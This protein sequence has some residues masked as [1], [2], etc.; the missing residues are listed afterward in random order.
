[1]LRYDVPALFL[2][3]LQEAR[4]LPPAQWQ[5]LDLGCGTGLCGEKIIPFA[6]TLIGVD[7]SEKML[8]VAARKQI[9]DELIAAD[10]LSYLRDKHQAFDLIIAGDVL[11]Y[12][13]DLA[14]VFSLVRQALKPGG[15][16]ILNLEMSA[17]AAFEMTVSGRFAHRKEYVEQIAA[18]HDFNVLR[19]REVLLR[20]QQHGQV[21]GHLFLLGFL[22]DATI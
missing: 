6:R 13:G 16:F 22:G 2:Q 9:Y 14:P 7:L 11:V 3:T 15:L 5:V 4:A 21:M 19:Y 18:Q 8:A 10:V 12:F 20:E 1:M 17:V